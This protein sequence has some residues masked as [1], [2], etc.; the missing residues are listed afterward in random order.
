MIELDWDV[1]AGATDAQNALE[2]QMFDANGRDAN[3]PMT[4]HNFFEFT[5]QVYYIGGIDHFPLN[6]FGGLNSFVSWFV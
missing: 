6:I 4:G 2:V 5:T 1:I 3:V